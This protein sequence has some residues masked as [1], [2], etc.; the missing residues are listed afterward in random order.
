MYSNTLLKSVCTT[1]TCSVATAA[2][3]EIQITNER[4]LD[5]II[6]ERKLLGK[7]ATTVLN[8]ILW[9]RNKQ[10]QP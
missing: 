5:T 9:N 10:Q 6:K 7:K 1:S 4:T 2:A 8:G 3:A